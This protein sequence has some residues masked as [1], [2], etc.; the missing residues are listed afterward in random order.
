MKKHVLILAAFMFVFSG[1]SIMVDDFR[2]LKSGSPYKVVSNFESV[3]GEDVY[4]ESLAET[5][6]KYGTPGELTNVE[7][8]QVT[9]FTALPFEQV[10]VSEDGSSVLNIYYKRNVVELTF[11]PNGGVWTKN[12]TSEAVTFFRRFGTSITKEELGITQDDLVMEDWA[13]VGWDPDLPESVPAESAE[14]TAQ[15]SQDFA[16]YTVEYYFENTDGDFILDPTKTVVRKGIIDEDTDAS[17]LDAAETEGYDLVLEDGKIPHVKIVADGTAV[18][19]LKYALK[20]FTVAFYGNGG[21]WGEDTFISLTGKSGQAFVVPGTENLLLDDYEFTGKWLDA[22]DGEVVE[23][24]SSFSGNREYYAQWKQVKAAYRVTYAY[25]AM[26]GTVSVDESKTENLKGTIGEEATKISPESL[27]GFAVDVTPAVIT[28][29][30]SGEVK[31]VYTRRMITVVF[32]ADDG[33]GN[34]GSWSGEKT[35]SVSG[36]YGTPLTL[37]EEPESEN[38][39]WMFVGWTDVPAK[40]PVENTTYMAEYSRSVVY[41][42]VQ[43]RFQNLDG[44]TWTVMQTDEKVK[45]APEK[46]T[47]A[48]ATGFSGD[49][50]GFSP[51]DVTN[52]LLS[53]SSSPENTVVNVDFVR[54]T[55]KIRFLSGEGSWSDGTEYKEISGKFGEDVTGVPVTEGAGCLLVRE[56]YRCS[57]WD[58]AIPSTYPSQDVSV[59]ATWALEYATYTVS[60]SYQNTDGTYG[61]PTITAGDSKIKVGQQTGKKP[62]DFASPTTGYEVPTVTDVTISDNI[63]T[64]VVV[65]KYPRVKVAYTFDL[66]GGNIEGNSDSVEKIGLYGSSFGGADDIVPVKENYVFAGWS[67]TPAQ[68]YSADDTF[69]AV[70]KSAGTIG[71]VIPGDISVVKNVSGNKATVTVTVPYESSKWQF[72]WY[73]DGVKNSSVARNLEV[74][75]AK[76]KHTI[77]VVAKDGNN[78]EFSKSV[79]VTV[80]E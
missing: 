18:V 5:E 20:T 59:T 2:N 72:Q 77:M 35:K 67:K 43:Y 13:L 78:S 69:K 64:N 7:A 47:T 50:S 31:V 55:Y 32:S 21:K 73:V 44:T 63:A 49:A 37:P 22:A 41:Y 23:V 11:N 53:E 28:Q 74:T 58:K 70:W 42:K 40:F 15:W 76:G 25:E 6:K 39:D 8:P 62:S 61:A 1:C 80:T 65:V 45:G 26:D 12:D 4:D 30:G 60:T 3:E 48:S 38:P 71:V 68:I 14:F 36:K 10:V 66:N 57:G 19:Q 75:L 34:S 17:P 27:E 51:I 9:G 52:V 56:D 46:N 29:D 33:N 54:N 79:T 16:K 24:D